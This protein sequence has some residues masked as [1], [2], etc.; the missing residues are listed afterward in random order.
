MTNPI[1]ARLGFV[2]LW[3][4]LTVAVSPAAQ[5]DEVDA[6]RL[7]YLDGH[8]EEALKIL[9]PAAE[10]GNANAQNIVAIAY[11]NGNGVTKDVVK[12]ME[13]Y[14]KSVAQGFA[15]AEFNLGT[16]LREAP[17]GIAQDYARAA[18]LFE[19]GIAKDYPH[20][21]W[22]RGRMHAQGEGGAVDLKAA[23][24]LYERGLALG[25]GQSGNA[26]AELYRMG[27]G[28][29]KD[30]VRAREIYTEA[31]KTGY[32]VAM[33]NLGY[34]YESGIGG[35]QNDLAAYALYLEAVALGDGNA[36]VNLADFLI[37]RPGY[38]SNNARAGAYCLWGLDAI[39]P[40]QLDRV[41]PVCEAVNGA[42]SEAEREQAA[43]IRA[44]W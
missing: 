5:A 14:E 39:S 6:A 21:F 25:N 17:D 38:W 24:G 16:L 35:E 9:I 31:A 44:E 33:G 22:E 34:M 20:A 4:C 3:L 41:K 36:G 11:E 26:L 10:A 42:L 8:H 7:A 43:R 15:K 32:G 40:E 29:E 37:N 23:I 2:A 28:V 30:E 18:A 12:A 19:A 27:N 13:W 1:F